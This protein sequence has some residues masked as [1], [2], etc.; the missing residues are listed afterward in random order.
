MAIIEKMRIVDGPLMTAEDFYAL[1]ESWEGRQE[2]WKGRLV[3]MPFNGG[4]H[5][6][7]GARLITDLIPYFEGRDDH[8]WITP[9][10]I[11][12]RNPDTVVGPDIAI[13]PGS[14]VKRVTLDFE[15]YYDVLPPLVIEIKSPFDQEDEIEAKNALYTEARVPELWWIRPAERTVTRHWPDRAPVCLGLGEVIEQVDAIPGF[16]LDLDRLFA[17]AAADW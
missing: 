15:G 8:F 16:S 17:P 5:S 14:F 2:L 11:L 10:I 6:W 12:E 1:P 13:I 4:P 3:E 9:G 7:I